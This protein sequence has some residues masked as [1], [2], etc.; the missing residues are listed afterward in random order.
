MTG[1]LL[2]V[3]RDVKHGGGHR[4]F[5][6][7]I[8]MSPEIACAIWKPPRSENLRQGLLLLH[9]GGGGGGD[10][11]WRLHCYHQAGYGTYYAG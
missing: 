10:V 3:H 8:A 4:V 7:N 6:D 9:G 1:K 2:E 11:G 5:V